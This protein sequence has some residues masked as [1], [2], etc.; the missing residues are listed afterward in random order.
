MSSNHPVP[1][2]VAGSLN[3]DLVLEVPRVP[4]AGETLSG[5]TFR[6]VPGGKGANQ[7]VA[8]ARLGGKVAMVGRVGA[9]EFGTT[10]RRGLEQDGILLDHVGVDTDVS[11]GVALILVDDSAQNRIVVV[12]GA[13]GTFAPANVDAAGAWIDGAKLVLVQLETPMP[14]VEHAIQRAVRAGVPVLLN[15]APAQALSDDVLRSVDYLVPNETEASMLTGIEVTDVTSAAAAARSLRQR[16]A[17]C[18]L[19][20]LGPRGV[21]IADDDGVRDHAAARVQAVDT[22][23]AGDTF[24]GG[25]SVGLVEGMTLDAAARFAMQAAALSVTRP[26]AQTSIPYRSEI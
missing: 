22:T 6:L 8:C 15:P 16:G 19:I 1:I 24:I 11:T 26:G 17:R 12:P 2:V 14:S 23:A 25:L 18:V 10:L 3:M 5:R 20:T 13:N 21:L 9:D 4:A 7:A